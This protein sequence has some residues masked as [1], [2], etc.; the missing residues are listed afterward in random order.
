MTPQVYPKLLYLT[1]HLNYFFLPSTVLSLGVISTF[2]PRSTPLIW[3]TSMKY[4]IP[5][6]AFL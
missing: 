5:V 3:I 1:E 6:R 2:F 4:S